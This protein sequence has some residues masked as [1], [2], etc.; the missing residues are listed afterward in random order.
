M[1][2]ESLGLGPPQGREVG[3]KVLLV[4][5]EARVD[6]PS[7]VMRA[8]SHRTGGVEGVRSE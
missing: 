1:L 7:H 6:G 3:V 4:L 5:V 2:A 8:L